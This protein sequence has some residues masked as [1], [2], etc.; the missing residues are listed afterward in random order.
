MCNVKAYLL[1]INSG[2]G[3]RKSD[4]QNLKLTV[5]NALFLPFSLEVM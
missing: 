3:Y 4:R 1:G 2:I 5:E